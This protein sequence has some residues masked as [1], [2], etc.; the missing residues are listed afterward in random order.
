M[1]KYITK[2]YKAGCHNLWR[3]ALLYVYIIDMFFQ[4]RLVDV[5]GMSFQVCLVYIT[6]MFLGYIYTHLS[7]VALRTTGDIGSTGVCETEN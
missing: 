6:D 5:A 3:P 4:V 2:K 7:Q 1:Q